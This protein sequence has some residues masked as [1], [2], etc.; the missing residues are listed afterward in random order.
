MASRMLDLPLP[1]KPVIEL[2]ASSLYCAVSTFHRSQDPTNSAESFDRF[3]VVAKDC[4]PSRDN[5]THSVRFEALTTQVSVGNNGENW[6]S[7]L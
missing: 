5:R 1:F 4:V 7:H 3:M 2:N 6:A